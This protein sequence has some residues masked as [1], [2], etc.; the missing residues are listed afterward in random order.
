MRIA[1]F[2]RGDVSRTSGGRGHKDYPFDTARRLLRSVREHLSNKQI[3]KLNADIGAAVGDGD[4]S[5]SRSMTL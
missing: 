3:A 1:W 4:Y 5:G 2:P